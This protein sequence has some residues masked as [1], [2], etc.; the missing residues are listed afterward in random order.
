[1]QRIMGRPPASPAP[2]KTG[3]APSGAVPMQLYVAGHHV[4]EGLAADDDA[5]LPVP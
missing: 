1:M 4:V 3:A 2:E 5:G